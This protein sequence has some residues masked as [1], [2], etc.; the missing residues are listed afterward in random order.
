MWDF[1]TL[2]HLFAV[3]SPKPFS[4]F[5]DDD[6]LG[7]IGDHTHTPTTMTRTSCRHMRHGAARATGGLPDGPPQPQTNQPDPKGGAGA[8][9]RHMRHGAARARPEAYMY[10]TGRPHPR[11]MKVNPRPQ[12]RKMK[13]RYQVDRGSKWDLTHPP[14]R[15]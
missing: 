14:K 13:V 1:H 15:G 2:G 10:P 12:R 6:V 3:S 11:K 7:Y 5:V 4:V 8:T 9:P